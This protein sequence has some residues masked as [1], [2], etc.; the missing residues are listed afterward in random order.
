MHNKF[1]KLS[2]YLALIILAIGQFSIIT[3]ALLT[4]KPAE[5]I[6]G[7]ADFTFNVQIGNTY[8]VLKDIGLGALRATALAASN[9]F[10]T[11]FVNKLQDKYKIRNFLYYDQYLT[12]YY[13]DRLLVDRIQDPDLRQIFDLLQ[14]GYITGQATGTNPNDPNAPDPRKALIPRIKQAMADYYIKQGGIDPNKIYNPAPGIS[15]RQYFATAQ[16]YFANP[17]S[18]TERNIQGQFGAFQS[19]ATTASQLEI[20]L[21]NGLK[22]GRIIGGTCSLDNTIPV[23][24]SVAAPT[25]DPVACKAA[26]GT[27]QESAVD[28]ARSFID[29]PTAMVDKYLTGSIISQIDSNFKPDN[30]WAVIG[31]LFGNFLFNRLAL[32]QPG[33]QTSRILQEYPVTYQPESGAI[34][35][36]AVHLDGDGIVD[37]YDTNNDGQA[38]ICV[39]GGVDNENGAASPGPPC[40]AS[41]AALT[42]PTPTPPTDCSPVPTQAQT[43]ESQNAIDFIIPLLEAIPKMN[44][45]VSPP[46]QDYQNA[47][48]DAVDQTNA[49]FPGVKALYA[50]YASDNVVAMLFNYLVGPADHVVSNQVGIVTNWTNAWRVTCP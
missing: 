46:P 29:N 2:S 36:T 23:P 34:D 28:I 20:A 7:I 19:A 21:G 10:L 8:D 5:A 33:N 15:D 35:G 30:F 40:K 38:D 14:R 12:N 42:T 43:E 27:W 41:S 45:V 47:V 32:D 44:P 48:Q 9:K 22:A 39:Y 26:G 16:A 31:S 4:P 3:T 24:P 6:F 49:N 1:V 17:P 25:N 37:G 13:L 18:F 50:P 11:R